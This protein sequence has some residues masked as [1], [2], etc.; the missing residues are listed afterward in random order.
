MVAVFFRSLVT[1]PMCILDWR[2][3]EKMETKQ[4]ERLRNEQSSSTWNQQYNWWESLLNQTLWYP[5]DLW[6]AF[7]FFCR[8]SGRGDWDLNSRPCICKAGTRCA[9]WATPP[10]HFGL[11]FF[12]DRISCYLPRQPEP[13]LSQISASQ[14]VRTKVMSHWRPARPCILR[15]CV[16]HPSRFNCG[17]KQIGVT[18]WS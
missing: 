11:V 1:V 2:R 13:L 12:G 8:V 14:V 6:E 9:A 18:G 5:V 10:V 15:T 17:G 7:F 4:K 3:V 16:F